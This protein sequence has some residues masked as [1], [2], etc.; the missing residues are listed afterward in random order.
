M[1]REPK[2]VRDSAKGE[3][4]CIRL[5]GVCSF[6]PE[7]TVFAHVVGV[8]MGHG[9]ALKT[10]IGCYADNKCHDV[11]DGRVKRPA[12]L[13]HEAVRIAFYEGVIET[14]LKLLEKGLLKYVN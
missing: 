8:R 3:Q 10:S 5:E 7:K 12:H 11:V 4:C 14:Q 9:M 13:S 6:D 1:P 2:K